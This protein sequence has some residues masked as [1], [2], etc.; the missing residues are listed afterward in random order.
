M[1]KRLKRRVVQICQAA[2]KLA[3]AMLEIAGRAKRPDEV[4]QLAHQVRQVAYSAPQMWPKA[5]R[6]RGA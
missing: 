4:R 3:D 6:E 5:F 2:H 1:A